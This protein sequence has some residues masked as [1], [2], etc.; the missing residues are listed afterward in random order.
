MIPVLRNPAEVRALVAGSRA[1]GRTVGL[2]PTMGA[3]HAGHAAL[4]ARAAEL[5]D[6][7]IVSVFV[8]PLQFDDPDDLVRYPRD[9]ARDTESAA[10]AGAVAVYA[11]SVEVMYPD[12]FDTSVVVDRTASGLEGAARPGHFRGVATVV[13]KLLNTVAP[14][15]AVFGRK[16]RQQLAVVARMVTDLDIPVRIVGLDTVREP[17]GLAMS[18][19][20]ERLDAASRAVAA[21]IPRALDRVRVS[22]GGGERDAARLLGVFR[23]VIAT[24]PGARLEYV[25]LSDADDLADVDTVSRPAVLSCAVL[26]GGV[27]L[28]DNVDLEP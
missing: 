13:C 12:G 11:P 19:R 2:V 8:N 25:S 17:D 16:D 7:V 9:L 14:D 20:N 23:Q 1:A 18:S 6:D 24:E 28:I 27:R 10:A 15:V 3:L 22:F 26:V 5:T 4:I 21:V